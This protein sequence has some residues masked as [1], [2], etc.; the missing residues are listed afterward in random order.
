MEISVKIP[1]GIPG[2]NTSTLQ[3][4][5]KN[6]FRIPWNN[7]RIHG[8][9]FLTIPGGILLGTPEWVSLEI[10]EE[11]SLQIPLG[12]PLEILYESSYE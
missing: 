11:I 10:T 1:L 3:K 5:V 9:I 8:E 4:Y 6:A 2:K 7:L 12:I